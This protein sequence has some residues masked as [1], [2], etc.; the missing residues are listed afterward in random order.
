MLKVK[1]VLGLV[2]VISLSGCGSLLNMNLINQLSELS[3]NGVLKNQSRQVEV[4]NIVEV[5]DIEFEFE[6]SQSGSSV[7]VLADENLQDAI[8]TDV[9]KDTLVLKSKKLINSQ[10]KRVKIR[11]P[12]IKKLKLKGASKALL[13]NLNLDILEVELSGTSRLII[14]GK[15]QQLILKASGSSSFEGQNLYTLSATTK[16][17]GASKAEVQIEKN[18]NVKLSGSS[19]LTYDGNPQIEIEDLSGSSKLNER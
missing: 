18:L 17:S 11:A 10:N 7:N 4:S 14:S 5:E 2:L 12:L 9:K 6:Q 1:T 3:G 15:V 19:R 13:E 16:L 8:Q